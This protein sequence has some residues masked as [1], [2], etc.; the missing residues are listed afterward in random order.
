MF[1]ETDAGAAFS[2]FSAPGRQVMFPVRLIPCSYT[3][4]VELLFCCVCLVVVLLPFPYAACLSSKPLKGPT[5]PSD[6][7]LPADHNLL[8]Q[9]FVIRARS[10]TPALILSLACLHSSYSHFKRFTAWP[11]LCDH[12]QAMQI[13]QGTLIFCRF[14]VSC[15]W[16][17]RSSWARMPHPPQR[18]HHSAGRLWNTSSAPCLGSTGGIAALC[19]MRSDLSDLCTWTKSLFQAFCA[20]NDSSHFPLRSLSPL[21]VVLMLQRGKKKEKKEREDGFCANRVS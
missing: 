8:Y 2:S 6:Y 14:S 16:M 13:S 3:C 18:G 9:N 20:Q 17:S 5:P 12:T 7:T 21:F 11:L 1:W 4:G 19:D 15:R 10:S